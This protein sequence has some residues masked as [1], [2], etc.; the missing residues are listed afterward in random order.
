MFWVPTLVGW[1][2]VGAAVGCAP[3]YLPYLVLLVF[4]WVFSIPLAVVTSSPTLGRW[5]V[6][7]G[8]F[9]ECL[10]REEAEELHA[11][12]AE[13]PGPRARHAEGA[14]RREAEAVPA[15]SLSAPAGIRATPD[16][17]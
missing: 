4:G 7:M 6:R 10:T 1:V 5:L 2:W 9:G 14:I 12:E 15:A 16:S 11:S 17:P 8:L 3:R 13:G